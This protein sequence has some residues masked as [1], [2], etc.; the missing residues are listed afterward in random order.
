MQRRD[1]RGRHGMVLLEAIVALTIIGV[2]GVTAVSLAVSSLAAIDRAHKADER[3][4]RASHFLDAV[5]LWT[6]ADL[7]RHLGDR[8]EGSWRLRIERPTRTLY[9]VSLRDST[10]ERTLLTTALYRVERSHGAP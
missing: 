9:V 8:A 1:D 10:G 7:D 3:S 4:Q 5:S 2:A 6:R